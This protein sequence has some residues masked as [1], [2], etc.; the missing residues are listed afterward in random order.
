MDVK[1]LRVAWEAKLVE[2]PQAYAKVVLYQDDDLSW[3]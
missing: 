2:I 3:W 1:L